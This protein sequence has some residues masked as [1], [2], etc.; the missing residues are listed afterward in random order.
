MIDL[1]LQQRRDGIPQDE[2][3]IRG[4]VDGVLDGSVTDAQR[5]AWLAFVMLQGMSAQET[6]W[7]TQ[8]MTESGRTLTWEGMS[9][10]FVDKHSTG[11][12]GDKVSL[13]LAPLWAYLGKKVPMLSGR[14]LGIT[15]GTLDKLEAIPGYRTDLQEPQLRQALEQVGCFINGQTPDIAPADRILYATRNETQTVPSI[16]LITASILSKKLVEGIE[17]LVLDVKFGSGAFMTTREDAEALAGSLEDVGNGAGVRTKAHLTPMEQP[18]GCLVGNALEVEESIATL[19]GQGPSDLVDL[20]VELSGEGDAAREALASG[21]AYP[22]WL[23]MVRAHGGDPEAPLHGGE[24]EEVVVPAK[25][26][27]VV[28]S[29][30][31]GLLGQAA[32]TLGAGRRRAQ[33]PVHFGVGLKLHA[34]VGDSVQAGQPLLT[35]VHAGQ[36]LDDALGLVEQA[37]RMA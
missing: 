36:G 32:F 19:Q 35:L 7:L 14:G 11:G 1:W 4:F 23:E 27:G 24:V 3:A 13:V 37:Y 31:A 5:G 18:L 26:S 28:Q 12:V 22:K 30:D 29:A 33:D 25:A 21:A 8:A 10:P 20:V 2:A 9:G 6:V 16:P 17:S 15:G 34:K